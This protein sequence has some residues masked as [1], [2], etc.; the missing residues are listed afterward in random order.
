MLAARRFLSQRC[1]DLIASRI[2]LFLDD[3]SLRAAARAVRS[4]RHEACS[5]LEVT[6]VE[7]LRTNDKRDLTVR[8]LRRLGPTRLSQHVPAVLQLLESH[9]V[10]VREAAMQVMGMLTAS[11]LVPHVPVLL[12]RL[13]A[14]MSA[15]VRRAAGYALERLDKA[16]IAEHVPAMLRALADSHFEVRC[17]AVDVL[18]KVKGAT[19]APHAPA[20]MKLVEEESDAGVRANAVKAFSL[21]DETSFLQHYEGVLLPL[22]QHPDGRLRTEAVIA[23]R[24]Q[25]ADRLAKHVPAL[26]PRLNDFNYGGDNLAVHAWRT[27]GGL[28]AAVLAQH[29]PAVLGPALARN[30]AYLL[31]ATA[32]SVL[33]KLDAAS[34]APHAPAVV[35]ML[36]DPSAK[37]RAAAFDVL[38]NLEPT[39]LAQKV[40]AMLP[41]LQDPNEEVRFG[42]MNTLAFV[43]AA[44]LPVHVR[45][46][47][48]AFLDGGCW[49]EGEKEEEGGGSTIPSRRVRISEALW[50]RFSDQSTDLSF[51]RSID[52]SI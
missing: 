34:L 15:S 11:A 40:P 14:D 26:L 33:S 3:E 5:A 51:Y 7:Q 32:L 31:R 29:L 47:V 44:S 45:P 52:I 36:E 35:S 20:L 50:R 46:L 49:E 25:D 23:L 27:F 17:A 6:M 18:T 30:T 19:L 42:A 1:D 4:L 38:I 37:V 24:L 48:R 12:E 22:L 2:C 13:D 21:I 9:I 39:L 28:S 43:D 41:L 10:D 16:D 8:H